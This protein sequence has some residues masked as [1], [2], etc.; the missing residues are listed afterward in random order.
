M[1][2]QQRVRAPLCEMCKSRGII[3]KAEVA[4]HIR[5]HHGD[6]ALFYDPQNLQSL[7]KKCHDTHKARAERSGETWSRAVGRDGWPL[8]PLHPANFPRPVRGK[9]GQS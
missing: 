5:R 2:R 3:V 9:S 7:C 6:E 1:S 8:D 4:D